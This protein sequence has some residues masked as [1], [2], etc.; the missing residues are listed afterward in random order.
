MRGRDR[1]WSVLGRGALAVGMLL[2][3]S[4]RGVAGDFAGCYE[5]KLSP[6]TPAIALGA[7]DAF[8]SPPARIAL[9][10]T[11]EHTWDAHGLRVTSAAGA[12]PSVHTFSYWTGDARQLHIVW[13]NGHSGLTMD[14]KAHGS[15]LVGTA[16]TFWDF[17]RPQQTSHVVATRISCEAKK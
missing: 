5:L 17:P 4:V 6:W 16:Q 8:A 12:D 10:T 7:D 14:L 13:T 2:S 3:N 9:T 1:A 15:G 11:P